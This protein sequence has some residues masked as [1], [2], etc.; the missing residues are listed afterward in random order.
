[1]WQPE[2][3]LLNEEQYIRRFVRESLP[4]LCSYLYSEKVILQPTSVEVGD[5]DPSERGAFAALIRMRHALACGQK[6]KPIIDA[7]KRG[8]SHSS[9]LVRSESKC[10][11]AGRLDIPLYL[12]RRGTNL[13]WPRSLPI[14]VAKATPTTPENQLV[15]H[16]LRQVL[17]RLRGV[18]QID[19]SAERLLNLS[20]SRWARDQLH[21]DPWQRVAT[22]PAAGERLR[23]EAEHRVRR[24]QTG[25]EPAYEAFLD[26]HRQWTFD[27]SRSS[28]YE[29]ENMVDL[30]LA[31]PA[32]DFFSDKVFEVWCLYQVIESFRRSGARMLAGPQPLSERTD[33]AICA[34]EYEG[35]R[36][37]IF[38]QRALPQT[39]A[40]WSYIRSQQPLTGIPD[41]TV[42]GTDG[43]RLLIDAK[44]REARSHTRPEETYKMLG[45]RENFKG[46][47][48]NRPFWAALCFLSHS[49]LY[50]EMG[51]KGNQRIVLIGAHPHDPRI[52]A[53]GGA[54]DTLTAEWLAQRDSGDSW[55]GIQTP[56]Q[57]M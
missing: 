21:S 10:V 55:N 36:F 2:C 7:I 52:C 9:E 34:L 41:I 20:L 24:R 27:T 14:L 28:Q 26:W 18:G 35:Y 47:F 38:Y 48:E 17:N 13:S 5:D 50:T 19:A 30:L 44:R 42:F 39:D 3:I 1:L 53:F 12:S 49:Q 4:L 56:L 46:L 40:G 6:L 15:V 8:Y 54:M 43:R 33:Q 25:N 23:R 32:G 45:Y 16:T 57:I 31:F 51:A 37:E 11:V 22:A 29:W